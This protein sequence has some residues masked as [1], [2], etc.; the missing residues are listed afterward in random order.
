MKDPF[1]LELAEFAFDAP[2]AFAAPAAPGAPAAPAA[3]AAV[4]AFAAVEAAD[5]RWRST[6]GRIMTETG[7]T[8]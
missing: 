3:P 8:C 1:V 7:R 6:E 5:C 2:A 4:D